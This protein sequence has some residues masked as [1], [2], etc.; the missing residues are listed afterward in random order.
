[1]AS[2]DSDDE[3]VVPDHVDNYYLVDERDEPIPFT[4]APILW[5]KDEIPDG[6]KDKIYLHG[7]VDNG[8]Q[9]LYRQVIAWNF[10]ISSMKPEISV[11]AKENI[12]IKLRK[13]R[14]SYED[15][16][17]TILITVHCL[18][19]LKKNPQ[20][21][22]KSLWD[23]LSRAFRYLS[24]SQFSI[25]ENYSVFVLTIVCVQTSAL[26]QNAASMM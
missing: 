1:M 2:S 20:M 10:D 26:S 8:L 15:M 13:P 7:V 24:N 19:L 4:A 25:C 16:I 18:H 3:S 22:E 5:S 14:K 21:S 17:R 12:W 9:K 23:H 11:L 6:G